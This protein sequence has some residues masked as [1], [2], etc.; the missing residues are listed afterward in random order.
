MQAVLQIVHCQTLPSSCQ[1]V[2]AHLQVL[3]AGVAQR[4][5]VLRA[6][7]LAD[8]LSNV[9]GEAVEGDQIRAE[10]LDREVAAHTGEHLRDTHIDRLGKG[11]GDSGEV[12]E[13]AADLVG[14]GLFTRGPPFLARLEHHKGIGLVEA[15]RVKADLVGAG[16]GDDHLDVWHRLEDGALQARVE[17]KCLLDADR[18]QLF[19]LDDDV[20]FVQHRHEGA[21]DPGEHQHRCKQSD[22]RANKANLGMSECPLQK[23][24]IARL[25]PVHQR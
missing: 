18:G 6:G 8:H 21:A 25:E 17:L 3:H 13:H 4:Q 23:A 10:H 20:A 12:V 14:D 2:K 11:V 5:R 19:Q 16:A 1:P 24:L 22:T 15:H 7:H 9:V